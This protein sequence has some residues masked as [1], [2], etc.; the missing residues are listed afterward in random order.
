MWS[1]AMDQAEAGGHSSNG[2]NCSCK[3]TVWQYTWEIWTYLLRTGNPWQTE[4]TTND[5]LL[6]QWVSSVTYKV[7]GSRNTQT[8]L[9]SP[10]P[11]TAW[12]T[13]REGWKPG[14]PCTACRQLKGSG[15]FPGLSLFEASVLVTAQ[16]SSFL[17]KP[18]QG[19]DPA[20]LFG[21]RDFLKH[22]RCLLSDL[23]EFLCRMKCS[24]SS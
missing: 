9:Q 7:I 23:K 16:Q 14:A 5:Q 15:P 10:K 24:T 20:R 12:Q 8:R 18:G 3:P 1:G 19:G 2:T 6:I 11:N 17:Y 4:D 13:A 22:L 21:F